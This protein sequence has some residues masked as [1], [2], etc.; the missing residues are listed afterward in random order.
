[1][2]DIMPMYI[3]YNFITANEIY[4]KRIKLIKCLFYTIYSEFSF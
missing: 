2:G 1:M 3:E 4:I